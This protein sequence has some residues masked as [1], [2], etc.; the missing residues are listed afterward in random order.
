MPNIWITQLFIFIFF[1]LFSIPAKSFENYTLI[2]PQQYQK[3]IIDSRQ[4]IS[5]LLTELQKVRHLNLNEQVTFLVKLLIDIPYAY[6][7]MGEGDWQSKSWIYQ[8]GAVHIDQNPVYRL[9]RLDCQT[10]VQVIL[11][12]LFSR[13]ISDFDKNLLK[14]S[15]GAAGNPQNEIVHFYNR[16]HFVDGDFNPLNQKNGLLEDITSK[17]I[18]SSY[19]NT[20]EAMIDRK[21]WLLYRQ[22]NLARTVQVLQPAYGSLMVER[23]QKFYQTL[24]GQKFKPEKVIL[25]YIPKNVLV[26]KDLHNHY[27]PNPTIFANLPTPALAEIVYDARKWKIHGKK[28]KDVIG[29]ELNVGHFGVIYKQD[30]RRGE[31]IYDNIYCHSRAFK[32]VDCH[33][34][35]VLCKREKCTELMFAH[36]T[37]GYPRRFYWYRS[38]DRYVC[39]AQKPKE[40]KIISCNR[41]ETLPLFNYLVDFQYGSYWYM[42]Y[43][44]LLGVHFEKIKGVR[45]ENLNI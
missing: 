42:N 23:F 10:F 2:Q 15:Y 19:T 12:L 45:P 33:V 29:T 27:Y 18:F 30:F 35:P 5:A 34:R 11:A 16:N 38:N 17:N 21:K 37:D 25:S 9:D 41:V 3:N 43:S 40:G 13:S 26:K 20:T 4:K 32:P 1:F 24:S 36:A 14:I 6:H 22:K 8:P 39:S 31:K 7:G 44:A 28:I